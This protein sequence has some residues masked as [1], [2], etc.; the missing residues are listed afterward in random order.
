M[1]N[2]EA[3]LHTF[4]EMSWS[5]GK[6]TPNWPAEVEDTIGRLKSELGSFENILLTQAE[7]KKSSF[8]LLCGGGSN[9]KATGETLEP[10]FKRIIGYQQSFSIISSYQD[11]KIKEDLVYNVLDVIE[12]NNYMERSQSRVSQKSIK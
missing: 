1:P 2:K 12:K 7:K 5:L 3:Y 10:I 4:K 9:A 11:R 8:P 6:C